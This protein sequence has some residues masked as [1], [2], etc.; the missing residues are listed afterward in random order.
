MALLNQSTTVQKTIYQCSLHTKL[1]N[2]FNIGGIL[3]EPALTIANNTNQMLLA[4][5]NAWKFNAVELNLMNGN[6]FVSQFGVQDYRHAGACA[7]SLLTSSSSTSSYPAGGVGIDLAANP[8]NG[9]T[10]AITVSNGT[11]TVQSLDPHPFI[12]GN[13]VYMSGNT[14]SVYNST[15]SF[16]SLLQ[17][18]GWSN[19]WVVTAV[20]DQ[21]H[22]QFA[23]T[24]GQTMTS[25][26]PGITNW[27]WMQSASQSDPNSL[28][29]PAPVT[30]IIAVDR[31]SPAYTSTGEKLSVAMMVD[32]NNGVLKFRLS[33]PM[34]TYPYQFN[35]TYQ[36][37]APKLTTPLS[38]FQWPDNLS[39]VLQEVALWQAF[40]FATG[41][42][43]AE[44]SAQLQ[45]A[46][47]AIQNAR[48]ADDREDTAE[49]LIPSR[50]LMSF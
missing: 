3:N 5:P 50:S 21:Y 23:A 38:I 4:Y 17:T 9:S 32:Y 40:R 42:S 10:G 39:F 22:F 18:S 25:G 48:A 1:Q 7:F 14:Q 15:W 12:V 43:T 8:I 49:A 20:P 24:G 6:F 45:M 30:P 37:R 16:N 13:T 29:F 47:M 33:E 19:G 34:G 31:L 11:A 26:A 36:A 46:Q 27:G 2:F 41:L 28:Q 44:T 35:V